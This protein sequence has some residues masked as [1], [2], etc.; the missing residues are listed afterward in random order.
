M[1]ESVS[2]DIEVNTTERLLPFPQKREEYKSQRVRKDPILKSDNVLSKVC[3]KM[4]IWENRWK[5]E[6]DSASSYHF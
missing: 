2:I 5:A 4:G 1:E 3:R 6:R